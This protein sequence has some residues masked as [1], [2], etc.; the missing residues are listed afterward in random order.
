MSMPTPAAGRG[1]TVTLMYPSVVNFRA[2]PNRLK[3]TCSITGNEA[4]WSLV[5]D[6]ACVWWNAMR[7]V[8]EKAR[9]GFAVVR[10]QCNGDCCLTTGHQQR[11]VLRLVQSMD[12]GGFVPQHTQAWCD[13]CHLLV[14]FNTDA[15]LTCMLAL[16]DGSPRCCGLPMCGKMQ[17]ASMHCCWT[18]ILLCREAHDDRRQSLSTHLDN[19]AAISNDVWSVWVYCTLQGHLLLQQMLHSV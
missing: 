10:Q 16:L 2:L 15:Q 5:G 4:A 13:C 9:V 18:S 19:A 3:M 1:F 17:V 8:H 14:P 12:A 11:A 7:V 6:A